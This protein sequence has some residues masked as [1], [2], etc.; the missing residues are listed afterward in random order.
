ML[1]YVLLG[2]LSYRPMSGYDMEKWMSVSTGNFW[3]AKLSQIYATLKSMEAS[4]LV[5]SYIEPQEGRPDRR[6]YSITDAG[7]ADFEQWLSMPLLDAPIKKDALLVKVFFGLQADKNALLS[8]LRVHL[9]LHK[10][11]RNR[12]QQETPNEIAQFL[13]DQPELGDHALLWAAT[14][15]YGELYEDTYIRWLEDVIAMIDSQISG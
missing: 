7:Q 2:F 1:K 5:A 8:Q 9:D 13:A 3:H 6:V 4:E 10:Q 14:L 12:Y 11:Q 15:R